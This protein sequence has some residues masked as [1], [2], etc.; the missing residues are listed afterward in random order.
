MCQIVDRMIKE[1]AA[2]CILQGY[3]EANMLNDMM[4]YSN[5]VIRSVIEAELRKVIRGVLSEIYYAHIATL[6]LENALTNEL[7]QIGEAAIKQIPA[8]TAVLPLV[9]EDL[10]AMTVLRDLYTLAEDALC[11][12]VEEETAVIIS[13][14]LLE[15]TL[16]EALH[17]TDFERELYDALFTGQVCDLVLDSVLTL[18]DPTSSLISHSLD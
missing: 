16:M 7:K 11:T 10:L 15:D 4:N 12:V 1:Q 14:E 17:K 8:T 13:D 6:F 18:A 2:M 9:T 5:D 3:V